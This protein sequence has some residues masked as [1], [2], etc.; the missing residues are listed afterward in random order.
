MPDKKSINVDGDD[1]YLIHDETGACV[2]A[3]LDMLHDL[4]AF[5]KSNSRRNGL[6]STALMDVI[7]PHIGSKGRTEQ[8]VTFRSKEAQRLLEKVGF[9]ITGEN[10]AVISTNSLSKPVFPSV[11]PAGLNRER[12]TFLQERLK[13]A[14]AYIRMVRDELEIEIGDDLSEELSDLA[15]RVVFKSTDVLDFWKNA[16]LKDSSLLN[17]PTQ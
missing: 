16:V 8:R 12:I 17:P 1:F 13:T 15:W 11:S 9:T 6:M 14:A 10:D 3:V 5:V 2:G 4:H 7:L